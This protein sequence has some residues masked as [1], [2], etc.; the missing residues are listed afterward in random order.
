MKNSEDVDANLVSQLQN[1]KIALNKARQKIAR[2]TASQVDFES[3]KLEFKLYKDNAK[4]EQ[5]L[6]LSAWY[7]LGSNLY[8][9][10]PE[11]QS[12][13]SWLMNQTNSINSI[14]RIG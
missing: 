12:N 7:R 1:S 3:L 6:I 4:K 10:K 13:P 8:H 9:R 5:K 11:E 14:F 2:L